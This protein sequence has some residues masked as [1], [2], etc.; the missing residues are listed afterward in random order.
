M[1]LCFGT[2]GCGQFGAPT[3]TSTKLNGER[4]ECTHVSARVLSPKELDDHVPTAV[5]ASPTCTALVTDKGR[6]LCLGLSPLHTTANFGRSIVAPI[7]KD[8]KFRL[9]ACGHAHILAL[10]ERGE[11]WGWGDNSCKQLGPTSASRVMQPTGLRELV[12]YKLIDIS[13]GKRHSIALGDNGMAYSWGNN[14]YG[15]LGFG[16]KQPTV[17]THEAASSGVDSA[18]H[19]SLG[20]ANETESALNSALKGKTLAHRIA[21]DEPVVSV[22]AGWEHSAFVTKTGAILT[23][24]FGMYACMRVL[25]ST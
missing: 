14:E 19:N 12:P 21:V 24:G 8:I 22:A 3:T 17:Q 6:C 7:A 23:C 25:F 2:N 13:A 4:S 11:L 5:S 15:Q 20:A 9:V 10:S 1:L 16:G 18:S